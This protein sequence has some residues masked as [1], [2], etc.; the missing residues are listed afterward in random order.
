MK[1]SE[2]LTHILLQTLLAVRNTFKLWVVPQ[3]GARCWGEQP[4]NLA[5][6]C[7]SSS[8]RRSDLKKQNKKKALT[9]LKILG[10]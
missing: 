6:T 9:D 7:R 5:M 3:E 8:L 2:N 10:R 4:V 1:L